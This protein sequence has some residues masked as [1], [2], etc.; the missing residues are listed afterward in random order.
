V[1]D[2]TRARWESSPDVDADGSSFGVLAAVL[3]PLVLVLVLLVVIVLRLQSGTV[4]L[5]TRRRVVRLKRNYVLLRRTRE[6]PLD[7]VGGATMEEKT[8]ALRYGT[9]SVARSWLARAH[10]ET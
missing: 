8:I 2:E 7:A 9:R 10:A 5:D 3:R 4:A 6:L 1:S